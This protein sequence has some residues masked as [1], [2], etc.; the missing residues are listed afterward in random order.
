MEPG[1]ICRHDMRHHLAALEG[2]LRQ[3][4][5]APKARREKRR[6]NRAAVILAVLPGLIVLNCVPAPADVLESVPV[7]GAL[8]RV[9][10]LRTCSLLWKG[11]G[12]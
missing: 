7:P 4:D 12:I 6:Y 5:A 3:G 9:L 8:V 11:T 1:R 2:M 10:D